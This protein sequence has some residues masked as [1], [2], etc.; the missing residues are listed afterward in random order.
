MLRARITKPDGSRGGELRR[1]RPQHQ[2]AVDRHVLRRPAPRCSASPALAP[3]DVLE[4]QY[5]VEDTA[6]RQPPLRLL[7]RRRL[8]AGHHPKLRY[9]YVVDMPAGR[10]LYWN[11]K[12]L[13]AGVSARREPSSDGRVLYR[14]EAKHVSRG[15]ARAGNAGLVRGGRHAP[16]LDL[17]DLGAGGPLLLGPGPRPAHARRELRRDRRRGADRR[18]PQGR[19]GG[20]AGHLR[21]RGDEHPLRG[22]G[23]RHPRVQAVPGGPGAGAPLRRLQG[24]GVAHPRACSRWR[25]WTA[26]SCCCGCASWARSAPSPRRW[27]PSTT[28]SS[29]SRSSTG[30]WTAPPS[31]TA[32]A[33]CPSRTG[34]PTCSSSSRTGRAASS[35]LPRPRAEDNVTTCSWTWRSRRTARP[36]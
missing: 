27:R 26:G 36:R 9:Q 16:R 2:R 7:G 8:R 29:T 12:T 25:A 22:A 1:H 15:H 35:P 3:G 4:L 34:G 19:P 17:P 28:P 32:R 13:G 6:Q 31:S 21:L 24:Q 20:G 10:T 30:T 23:V 5:R 11:E 33:S 18:G 14:F